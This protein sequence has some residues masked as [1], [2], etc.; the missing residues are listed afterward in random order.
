LAGRPAWPGGKPDRCPARRRRCIA[1]QGRRIAGH[2]AA[3]LAAEAGGT[4]NGFR[5]D[6][7]VCADPGRDGPPISAAS[8][9]IGQ[10]QPPARLFGTECRQPLCQIG[11]R[12]PGAHSGETFVARRCPEPDGPKAER[13]VVTAIGQ[14]YFELLISEPN[15]SQFLPL[16]LASCICSIGEKSVELV[17]R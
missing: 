7:R 13:C 15:N 17:L 1:P 9:D 8:S 4:G 16:N 5:G 3:D 14:H 2:L 12:R 10:A 11:V 6:T